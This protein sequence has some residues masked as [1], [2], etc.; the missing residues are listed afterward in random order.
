MKKVLIIGNFWPYLPSN[1]GAGRIIE[2]VNCLSDFGWQAI[3]LTQPLTEKISSD[4]FQVIEVPFS[5]DIFEI[6]R[7]IFK[8]ILRINPQKSIK[9]QIK[10]KLNNSKKKTYLD[11]LFNIYQEIFGYPDTEKNWQ[12][13]AIEKAEE[14]IK[15]GKI[16]AII[17]EY[18]VISHLIASELKKK[19]NIPWIADFCDL[20]SENHMYPYSS[21]RKYF[22]KRLEVKI[23][24]IADAIVTVSQPWADKL[25][26]LHKNSKIYSIPHG[27]D[28]AIINKRSFPLSDKFMITYTGRIYAES[29][30]PE[31]FFAAVKELLLE[32]VIDPEKLLIRFYGDKDA[33]VEKIIEKYGLLSVCI[34]YDRLSKK[35][36]I[37]KQQESQMLL[38]FAVENEKGCY[39]LKIYDYLAAKRP[40]IVVGGENGDVLDKLLED[41][42]AGLRGNTVDEIK[43]LLKEYYGE[44]IKFREVRYRGEERSLGDHDYMAV[45]R[46]FTEILNNII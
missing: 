36:I 16:D 37:Q 2:L 34:F 18:P 45:T 13:P 14:L 4:K 20:W 10:Q 25:E 1:R 21:I 8:K 44:Y 24:K 11:I 35:D 46:K 6:W 3:I 19:Y 42:G 15:S 32:R 9:N 5:G 43:N 31:P 28:P 39:T 26:S 7:K 38:L 23:L 27:F 17:S 22:D 12:K 40:I 41:T 33:W 30:N 29:E